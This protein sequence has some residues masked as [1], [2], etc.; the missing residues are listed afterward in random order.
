MVDFILEGLTQHS[1]LQLPLFLLFL[2][3]DVVTVVG[4]LGMILLITI[5]SQLYSPMY[6]FLIHFSSIDLYYSFVM[7]P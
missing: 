5:S 4:N 6:Y 1:E 7:T 3:I 2:G